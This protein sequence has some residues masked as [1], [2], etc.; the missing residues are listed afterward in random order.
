MGKRLLAELQ[1]RILLADGAMGTMLHSQGL[2]RGECQEEWNVSHREEVKN[3]HERYLQA[4]CNL[5]L[6]NTFG[7]N[8]FCLKKFGRE[9]KVKEFNKAGVGI[10]REVVKDSPAFILGDVGPTGEFMEPLGT[11]T[12][13]AMSEVFRE[14]ILILAEEGVD[15]LII[16]TMSDIREAQAAIKAAEGTKLPVLASLSFNPG[17]RGFRTMMGVDIPTALQGL[18][19]AGAD[20]LGANCGE[21]SPKELAEIIKEMRSLTNKPLLAQPN[22]GKPTLIEGSTVYNQ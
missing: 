6:T 3:I 19:E 13:E 15:A 2:G 4:G 21:V 7:G 18:M 8:R 17:K 22:A 5:I 16:E 10:V 14:Q 9:D 1:E 20:V 12:F 11:V